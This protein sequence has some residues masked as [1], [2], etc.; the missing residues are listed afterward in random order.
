MA[1]D[2]LTLSPAL[3]DYLLAH[4]LPEHPALRR[5]REE[6][7]AS[8]EGVMQTAPEQARLLHLLVRLLGARRVLEIGTY[9][10]YSAL[11]MALALPAEGRLVAL[12]R[13]PAR[14]ARGSQAFAEAGV[15]ER[16]A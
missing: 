6:A 13:D 5:L 15:G 2:P 10:G 4:S 12:E 3:R 11:W 9:T 1:R 16:V 8:P 14:A 7:A